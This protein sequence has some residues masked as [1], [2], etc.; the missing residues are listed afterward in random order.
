MASSV[1]FWS[2]SS[3]SSRHCGR[4]GPVPLRDGT[5]LRIRFSDQ[6]SCRFGFVVV[7][8]PCGGCKNQRTNSYGRGIVWRSVPSFNEPGKQPRCCHRCASTATLLCKVDMERE[9]KYI[10][11]RA[12]EGLGQ[13]PVCFWISSF[14]VFEKLVGPFSFWGSLPS[15]NC[16]FVERVL[17]CPFAYTEL[18]PIGTKINV[19]GRVLRWPC[20][21]LV[22]VIWE[23]W[24]VGGAL[25]EIIL[26]P[27]R[28][29]YVFGVPWEASGCGARTPS[30]RVKAFQRQPSMD[31]WLPGLPHEVQKWLAG[32]P[33]QY[34]G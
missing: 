8:V 4:A 31:S 34:L 5:V 28:P 19:L 33:E 9:T 24:R 15:P 1:G 12:Q 10:R 30:R 2:A 16:F 22:V 14:R 20:L 25:P 29:Y 17:P 21:V 23:S 13:G 3:A 27:H 32:G 11:F 18:G 6:V 26:G 7:V